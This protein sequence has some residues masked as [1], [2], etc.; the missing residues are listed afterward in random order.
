MLYQGDNTQAFGGTFLTINLTSET[1]VTISKAV[2]KIGCLEKIF[3]NPVFP[4]VVN[5]DESET[6]KLQVNNT[7]YLAVWDE[8]GRKLTCEGKLAFSTNPRRV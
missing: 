3:E 1:P 5:F 4:L 8:Q 6:S 7:A 2:L